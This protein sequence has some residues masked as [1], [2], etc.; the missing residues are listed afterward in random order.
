MFPNQ[1]NPV[2]EI[3]GQPRSSQSTLLRNHHRINIIQRIKINADNHK[4]MN[5]SN[6]K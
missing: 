3:I 6:L 1:C 2:I 5:N 4:K